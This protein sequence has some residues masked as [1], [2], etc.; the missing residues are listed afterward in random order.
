M[1]K[2]ILHVHSGFSDGL[3]TVAEVLEEVEAHSDVDVV[4]FT[5]HDDV[6]SYAAALEWKD[7]HPDSRVQPL[8]GCEVTAAGFKHLLAFVTEPPY[9]TGPWRKFLPLRTAVQAI[10]DAG[11]LVVVPHVDAFWIG[12]GRRR[13][14]DMAQD[15][16]ILGYELLTPVPG[17]RRAAAS[18]ERHAA[19][20]PLFALGGS[21]AHHLED[22][23]QVILE[24]PGRTVAEFGAALRAGTVRPRWGNRGAR[25]AVRRQL[26]QHTRALV[27]HPARQVSAWA[28]R[29]V[30]RPPTLERGKPGHEPSQP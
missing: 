1:G 2:A 26:Q 5:D 11:G 20:A 10:H 13:L 4:G 19:Q 28:A 24:F 15:L 30:L 23:Y 7:R 17:A 18:L 3:P 14:I 12:V 8:W 16:G 27:G 25:V 29:R 6:R 21:D 22:L 9:P